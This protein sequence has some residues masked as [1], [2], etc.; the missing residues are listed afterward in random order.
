MEEAFN[1]DK[2]NGNN[3][4]KDVIQ[5]KMK[6]VIVAF[7]M[8]S[9][10]EKVPIGYSRLRVNPVFG[11]K[12]DLTRKACL[13]ADGHLTSGPIDST[14]TGVDSRETVRITLN[15]A[16]LHGLNLWAA[17]I[18]NTFLQAPTTEKYWVK[19]GGPEFGSNT[20]GKQAVLIGAHNGMK[21]STC[22]MRNHLGDCMDHMGYNSCLTDPDLWMRV[23]K[24]G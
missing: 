3:H 16:A 19:R 22:D 15:H 4:R 11:I 6:N 17:G 14:Y 21:F 24:D 23:S 8:L 18:M 7:K 5:K 1:L 9:S 20:V 2:Q 12:L 13:V 10:N